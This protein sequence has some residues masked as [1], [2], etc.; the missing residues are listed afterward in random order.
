MHDFYV[1][2]IN[3]F[4]AHTDDSMY[5]LNSLFALIFH[6]VHFSYFYS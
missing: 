5:S 6:S 1:Y 3:A 2:L 4:K